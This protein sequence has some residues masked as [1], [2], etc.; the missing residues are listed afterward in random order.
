MGEREDEVVATLA[1][2]R[3]VGTDIVTIG[4][5]LRPTTHH[6]PVARW[7]APE[8]FARLKTVGEA[9]GI[10]HIE[11]SPLTRSS[12]HPPPPPALRFFES[13]PRCP[14]G[15]NAIRGEVNCL[16]SRACSRGE[17]PSMSRPRS[18][19]SAIVAIFAV[20]LLVTGASAASADTTSPGSYHAKADATALDLKVFGQ[21]ITLGVT[22]AENASDPSSAASGLGALVPAI[23]NEVAQTAAATADSPSDD[24]PEVCGPIALPAEFPVVAL[25][26]ACSAA[27]ASVAGGF[28]ASAGDASVATIDVNG[29]AVLGQV[30]GPLNQP[31]IGDLLNGLQPVFGTR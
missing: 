15:S 24:H 18:R 3:A 9:M 22:H 5:Y 7:W 23:G 31:S 6:L 17:P 20:A 4:Q 8:E 28:P 29:N 1:D 30:T 13:E 25:A 16:R 21:G 27:T 26:T 12:Y 11:S 2:L 10:G 19:N 14:G